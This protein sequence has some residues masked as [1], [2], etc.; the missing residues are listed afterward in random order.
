MKLLPINECASLSLDADIVRHQAN[1]DDMGLY[2]RVKAATQRLLYELPC[3]LHLLDE[4]ECSAFLFFCWDAID[5]YLSAFR[6]GRLSYVGYLAQVVRK[7]SRYFIAQTKSEQRREGLIIKSQSYRYQQEEE[8]EAMEVQRPYTPLPGELNDPIEALPHLFCEILHD[9]ID[10]TDALEPHQ[11]ELARCFTNPIHRRRLLIVLTIC[12]AAV[13][14]H[15]LEESA[16]LLRADTHLLSRYLR[17]AAQLLG[18]KDTCRQQFEEVSNRHF[19]RLLEIEA[20]L[21]TEVNEE[22][23]ERLER[24]RQWTFAAYRTKIARIQSYGMTLTHSEV[25]RILNIPKGTVDSSVHYLRKLLVRH[26]DEAEV[27]RYP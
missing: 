9:A 1:P 10:T 8:L 11:H 25:G 21:L 24:L 5:H 26:M 3:Y 6:P 12:P 4:E 22:E 13:H 15:L 17:C 2:H 23:I 16:A 20:Q 18:H 19:R 27:K 14:H 7:R